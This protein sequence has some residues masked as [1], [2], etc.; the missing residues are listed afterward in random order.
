[1]SSGI[2]ALKDGQATYR[3]AEVDLSDWNAGTLTVR[4]ITAQE[5]LN[6][7]SKYDTEDVP[8]EEGVRFYTDLVILGVVEA[9]E[10]VFSFEDAETLQD[11]PLSLLE[12]I[13][14]KVMELSGIGGA[15]QVESEK[16]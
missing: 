6:L 14:N 5:H 7:I 2:K 8:A 1:M 9:G 3:T 16:N 12:T 15:G 4:E 10:R 13:A 11:R